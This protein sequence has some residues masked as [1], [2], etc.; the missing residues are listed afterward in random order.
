[1]LLL[2]IGLNKCRSGVVLNILFDKKIEHF[3]KKGKRTM[4]KRET[5][6]CKSVIS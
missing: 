2:T 1:M 4:K 3:M 5:N 6:K